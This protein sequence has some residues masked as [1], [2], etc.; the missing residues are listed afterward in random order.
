MNI[1]ALIDSQ[2]E[3]FSLQQQFYQS[4]DVFDADKLN[5]LDSMWH[6]VGHESSIDESGAYFLIQI[7]GEELIIVRDHDNKVRAFYNVCRHRGSRICREKVGRTK[8]LICPYHA[9]SYD[10]DGSLKSARLMEEGFDPSKYGLKSVPCRVLNGIVF[11]SLV[12]NEAAAAHFPEEASVYLNLHGIES[13]KVSTSFFARSKSNWKLVVENFLECYHCQTAHP[14]YCQTHSPLKLLAVGAGAG[15][16]P[17]EAE[18]EYTKQEWDAWRERARKLGYP[19]EPLVWDGGGADRMPIREGFLTESKDGKP[20]APL[21]GDFK[22]YDGGSTP[23]AFNYL[24]YAIA[25]S[26]HTT[27]IRFTPISNQV[28]DV[29]AI[30]LVR[31]DAVEEKDYQPDV[32]AWLWLETLKQDITITDNNQCGVNSAAYEPGPYSRQE[33]AI[34]H[35]HLWYFDYLR[36]KS[37]D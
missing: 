14:E 27:L 20:V 2:K 13:A 25:N 37:L 9:W 11:V 6:L 3:G 23:I 22:E 10:L 32:V 26:D 29:E 7:L 18:A 8:L 33:A 36:S 16:G 35:F 5:V 24:S 4:D 19:T 15:S 21:M 28:T 30:W 1:G 34:Q 12:K 17:P 31:D